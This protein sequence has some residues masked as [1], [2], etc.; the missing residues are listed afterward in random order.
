ME[1]VV[2]ILFLNSNLE[3]FAS[4][5]K[6]TQGTTLKEFFR[7]EMGS[8]ARDDNFRISLN[9]TVATAETVLTNGDRVTF[10]PIDMKGAR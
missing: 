5:R 7:S 10:H 9:G 3:G 4:K 1:N 6:L 8:E 2:E